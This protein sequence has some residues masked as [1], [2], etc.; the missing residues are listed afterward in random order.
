MN[1]KLLIRYAEICE[2][3]SASAQLIAMRR[4]CRMYCDDMERIRSERQAM[5]HKIKMLRRFEP[6][7]KLAADTL[8]QQAREHETARLSLSRKALASIGRSIIATESV[9]TKAIGFDRLCDLLSINP[10][11]RAE[12]KQNGY[13]TLHE[14]AFIARL[15]DSAKPKREEWGQGGPL[16]NACMYA[17]IEFIQTAPIDALPDPFAQG[18]IF[19]PKLPLELRIVRT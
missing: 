2:R 8:E 17:A 5:C 19:G 12:A 11:H 1:T 15:E 9:M 13:T 7:T 14:L 10:V 4:V 16:F 6:F 18:E 3:S